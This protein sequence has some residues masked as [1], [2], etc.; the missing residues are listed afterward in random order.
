MTNS[1]NGHS[2]MA[3]NGL[4][5]EDGSDITNRH[6][7]M[8]SRL[9]SLIQSRQSNKGMNNG[10][11]PGSVYSSP[12]SQ[13]SG[14]PSIYTGT[15]ISCSLFYYHHNVNAYFAFKSKGSNY[16]TA[17]ASTNT[18]SMSPH[19][20][21][22]SGLPSQ[23]PSPRLSSSENTFGQQQLN[24]ASSE[25]NSDQL[26]STNGGEKTGR[27]T[28]FTSMDTSNRFNYN[29][30]YSQFDRNNTPSDSTYEGAAQNSSQP[31][32]PNNN[33][34]GP[35]FLASYSTPAA[36]NQS[37]QYSPQLPSSS[38][39]SS[40]MPQ[41]HTSSASSTTSQEMPSFSNQSQ[42]S[43]IISPARCKSVDSNSTRGNEVIMNGLG[44]NRDSNS[45]DDS[46]NPQPFLS[47]TTTSMNTY[48]NIINT[49]NTSATTSASTDF[50]NT[51]SSDMPCSPLED[52]YLLPLPPPGPTPS[53]HFGFFG[54]GNHQPVIMNNLGAS[55]SDDVSKS[56]SG[57]GHD[58]VIDCGRLMDQADSTTSSSSFGILTDLNSYSVN[59]SDPSS[60]FNFINSESQVTTESNTV[61]PP[62]STFLLPNWWDRSKSYGSNY[63][64]K[65]DTT[66]QSCE[67]LDCVED[68][69][70]NEHNSTLTL[71]SLTATSLSH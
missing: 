15:L 50:Y 28:P 17:Q 35:Q 36:S 56:L 70:E 42:S 63:S 51:S 49:Y 6:Q 45:N 41:S 61:L 18:S 22:T 39:P 68:K 71:A 27:R 55:E 46:S 12:G 43:A 67:S 16:N 30:T 23:R 25:C 26:S 14:P 62:V 44:I 7:M 38:S 1:Y 40:L 29:N 31:V 9:K 13:P 10:A 53:S 57:M 32:R 3:P 21:N 11:V 58:M 54:P 64:N 2:M 24:W 20:I 33:G 5:S 4:M 52:S 48:T 8:N 66:D 69:T 47:N 34:T 60:T 37:Q 59:K 65:M 19:F